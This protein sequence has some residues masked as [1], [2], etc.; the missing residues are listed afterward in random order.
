MAARKSATGTPSNGGVANRAL[1]EEL[2]D[3]LQ[4]PQLQPLG[5]DSPA[6]LSHQ[7]ERRPPVSPVRAQSGD[8]SANVEA[9]ILMFY[10]CWPIL[11]LLFFPVLIRYLCRR[12]DD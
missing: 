1:L 12:E 2:Q 5:L 4:V 8:Q 9:A 6:G 7:R 10:G 3:P 11:L